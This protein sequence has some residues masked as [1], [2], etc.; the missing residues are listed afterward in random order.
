MKRLDS[1][2]TVKALTRNMVKIPSINRAPGQETAI[3]RYIYDYYSGL[4]YF[5]NNPGNVSI[6]PTKDDFVQR[7][8]V[9]AWIR[10]TKGPSGRAVVLLSHTDTVG[11]EDYDSIKQWACDPDALP[12]KLLQLDL[13]SDIVEDIKSGE[14]MFGRGALD[15]KSGAAGHMFLMDYFSRHPDELDGVLI[16]MHTCDEEAYCHGIITALDWLYE[17]KRAENLDF[18][19]CINSDYSTNYNPGDQSRYIYYGCIGKVLPCFYAFGKE[20][21]VGQAFAGLDPNLLLSEVTRDVSLNTD[22]CDVA[23]GETTVPPISLRFAD[24]KEEYTVQTAISSL[25]CFNFFTHS[26]LPQEVLDK[27]KAVAENS[28]S[29]V[30]GRL[31]AQYEKYCE[32]SGVPFTPLPWRTKVLTWDEFYQ[33]L[34]AR[35][36]KPFEDAIAT[37][38]KALAA[39]HPALDM[40]QFSCR[41][42]DEAWK[43]EQDKSPCIIVFLGSVFHTHCG[44]TR[45]DARS[46]ALLDAVE[47]SV[48]EVRPHAKRRL[49][50]RMFY[51]Y[52]ADISM[53]VAP[54]ADVTPT[55]AAQ[56]PSWGNVYTYDLEASLRVDMPVC[57]IG[58][59]GRDGHMLTERVDMWHTFQNIPDITYRTI[60]RLLG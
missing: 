1:F 46:A 18:A 11:I 32:L 51:P 22:L 44:L 42:I 53:I 6:H 30:V 2:E 26:M 7:H 55:L 5:K 14:F 9:C 24:T 39:S 29:T 48:E 54:K 52:I 27:C 49:V 41:V 23:L 56:M 45:E 57:N 17:L 50:T 12:E 10:G 4:E 37:F 58:T 35:H 8:N 47:A 34:A 20:T 25:A 3:A 60:A 21:H 15:M 16:A 38:G 33:S 40:R 31:S 13:P 43:W 36:G 28:F 19:A 59:F